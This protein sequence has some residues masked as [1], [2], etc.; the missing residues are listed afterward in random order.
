MLF[1]H[2]PANSKQGGIKIR[3]EKGEN[4]EVLGREG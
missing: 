4:L 2:P 3:L 1:L